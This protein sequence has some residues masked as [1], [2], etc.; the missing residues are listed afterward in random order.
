MW[1]RN[2][3]LSSLVIILM[4]GG[5]KAQL[6]RRYTRYQQALD[7]LAYYQTLYP[8]ICKLDTM[9][10]STRD[11]IPMLRFKISN[12]VQVDE[13]EPAVFLCGGVHADEVLGVEVVMWFI[14]DFMHKYSQ[15]DTAV[16]TY[17]N[18]LAIFCVP[19]INPEGHLVDEGGNTVWRKNKCDNDSN[20]VFDFHD[21]V[22][23]N[24][25]YDFGWGIDTLQVGLRPESL[26]YRGTAPFTQS[27]NIA[28]AAFGHHYEP[29]FAID[30]HSPTYGRAEKVYY[31]WYWYPSDG[32][33]GYS[34]DNTLM[35]TLARQ[36]AGLIINDRGDSTYE[37]REGLVDKGDF[38]SYFYANF[39]T[40][41]WSVEISD[42][43]IQDTLRV[44]G[45]CQ[46]HL[47][48]QYYLLRRALGSAIT[49]IIRDSVTLEP[50][51][52]EVQVTGY[53]SPDIHPR[54]SR[55]DFG[56]YRRLMAPGSYSLTFLKTGYRTRTTSGVIVVNNHPT[57]VDKLLP[58]I[59][60]RPPAP[61][62]NYPAQD[63]SLSDT[64]VTFIWHSS[65]YAAHY[66]LEIYN[67]PDSLHPIYVDS[68]ITDS[69][70]T[71]DSFLGD[72]LYLWRV[73]GGNTY[74]W[75]PYSQS[76]RFTFHPLTG[77]NEGGP[78][79]SGFRLGRNYPNPFNSETIISFSV[80]VGAK[81]EL[82]IYDIGGRLIKN[83]QIIGSNQTASS[84]VVWDG[85]DLSGHA[86][87][88]GVYFYR[89]KSA[90]KAFSNK[91]ILLR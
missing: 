72:S 29:L 60:P 71:V 79:P 54:L 39:G 58:P 64:A 36:F 11:S 80:P 91:M 21:G 3:I 67:L 77:I 43:T 56:R 35:Q 69:T 27:E 14:H 12:N 85:T 52:A 22:D 24:R 19:F 25:N 20:G 13:D 59:N 45:I 6:P 57:E 70:M 5:V 32:G 41:S 33:H 74:G 83:Y 50:I 18:N 42:T 68:L 66:L 8:N 84:Q 53:T 37:A 81:A 15:G 51:Q 23:N 63:T 76:W 90:G 7:T 9:G 28:M 87:N 61:L 73:K 75:G 89:L 2:V 40:F 34:P 47:P 26:E 30:Y 31:D 49:G 48:G 86:V 46:R 4:A 55:A 1:L 17:I 44:D 16:Q 62:L 65:S 88:S 38:K 10:Y 82:G 78:I